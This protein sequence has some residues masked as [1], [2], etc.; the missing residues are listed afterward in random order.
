MVLISRAPSSTVGHLP[1]YLTF[2]PVVLA[3]AVVGGTG[4]GVLAT[5]LSALTANLL[6]IERGG[7]LEPGVTAQTM[8]L[9]LF[10]AINLAIS[11]LGG[12]FRAKSDAL[13]ENE[14]RLRHFIDQ[15]PVAIAMLD[16]QMRYLAASRR[17]LTAF[18]LSNQKVLGRCHYDVFP[19]IPERWKQIHR[20]CLAGAIESADEDLFQRADGSRQWV[21]WEIQPWYAAPGTIGGLVIFSEEITARMEAKEPCVKAK[22]AFAPWPTPSPS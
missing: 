7:N 19:E 13:R 20:R 8:R 15:A 4:P 17:W 10:I 11:V 22:S 6:F 3:A 18:S 1:L 21:R 9:V 12:R 2:F 5:I 16:T 14:A